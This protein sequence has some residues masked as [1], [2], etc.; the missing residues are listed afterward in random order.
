VKY[1]VWCSV[2]GGLTGDHEAWLKKEGVIIQFDTR[3][4]ADAEVERLIE[5]AASIKAR[6]CGRANAASFFYQARAMT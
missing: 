3:E 2:T 5:R 4:E 6:G 1:G